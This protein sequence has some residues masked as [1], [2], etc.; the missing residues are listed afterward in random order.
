[1]GEGGE[2][3]CQ[4]RAKEGCSAARP[5]A[6]EKLLPIGRSAPQSG[7]FIITW[8]HLVM[9]ERAKVIQSILDMFTNPSYLEIGIDEGST[10]R[11]LTAARK[12][13]VD[14]NFKFL[15]SNMMVGDRS[16]EYVRA[17]SD[18][19]FAEICPPH[20]RFDLAF[21]DG[22]HTFE[23]TLRDLLN[24]LMRLTPRGVVVIDDILPNSYHASMPDLRVAF[25]VRDYMARQHPALANDGTWMGDVFKLAFFIQSFVQPYSYATVAENHGQ[26]IM[27][28]RPRAGSAVG[29][30][31]M[32]QIAH[33]EFSDTL[34]QREVFNVRPLAEI[35]E[36]IDACLK[37]V[38]D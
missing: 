29:Q 10:F 5:W 1:M 36:S 14:P 31:K 9:V 22:L 18:R 11:M 12:I 19:Y 25:L 21:I 27:W 16:I 4:K 33:L 20:E 38:I 35:L 6:G 28:P 26:L 34:T 15:P 24:V 8:K 23:Q 3:E 2:T 17:T 30:H 7:E 13:G 37:A 32:V